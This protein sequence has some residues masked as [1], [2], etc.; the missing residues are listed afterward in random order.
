MLTELESTARADEE[1]G[2]DAGIARRGQG[3]SPPPRRS[4]AILNLAAISRW[5]GT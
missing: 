1:G 5:H 3:Q 2:D 4:F